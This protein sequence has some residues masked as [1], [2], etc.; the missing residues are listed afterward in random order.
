MNQ[1]VRPLVVQLAEDGKAVGVEVGTA[2]GAAA[3]AHDGVVVEILFRDEVGM[4]AGVPL[5]IPLGVT[6]N[7]IAVGVEVVGECR[8]GS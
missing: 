3:I 2:D 7:G 5:G 4:R 1:L 6:S 8:R